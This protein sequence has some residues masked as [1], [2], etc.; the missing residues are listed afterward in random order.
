MDPAIKRGP[1]AIK[2]YFNAR[3]QNMG[4][5]K[6]GQALYDGVFHEEQLA[7]IEFNGIK[8]YV[9]GLNEFAPDVKLIADPEEREAKIK[10]IRSVVAQVERELAANVINEDDP[11]FWNKLK[12]LRPDND[13][14][15]SRITLRCGNEP[16]FLEPAKDPY[17]LIKLYAIA[18]GGFS[19][20]SKSYEEARSKAKPPKFYLDKYEDTVSTKTESKKLRNKALAELQKLFDKNTNKLL[21]IAKVVDTASVQYRKSTPTD[22][23]YDNMDTFINGEGSEKNANRAAQMFLDA[24]EKDMETLKLRSM[25]KDATYYKFIVSKADGFIYEAA[26]SALMGRTPADVVEWLKNPLNE[27]ILL[28]LTKKVEKYCNQ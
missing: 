20:V 25:V 14:F 19:L 2:P 6:Y 12:L 16:L 5:E 23:L 11:E 8:R 17:D 4:L 13:D 3:V 10:E 26:S 24:S 18:A 21:Y 15:W 27:E 28:N 7:C 1:I 9:T 22:V